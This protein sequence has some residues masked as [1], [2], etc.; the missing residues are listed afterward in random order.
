MP[1]YHIRI[2]LNDGKLIKGVKECE[3]RNI[4]IVYR[5]Y[6]MEADKHYRASH[7]KDFECFMIS[8]QS[9][10]YREW[11]EKRLIKIDKFNPLK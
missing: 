10:I 4:D 3:N 6:S 11:M 2:L 1:Y 5:Q 9:K 8:R 7:I